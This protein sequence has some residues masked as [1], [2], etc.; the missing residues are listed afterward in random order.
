MELG[1]FCG[2]RIERRALLR[3]LTLQRCE[4]PVD[5][6]SKVAEPLLRRGG[7]RLDGSERECADG[8][9]GR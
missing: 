6:R 7:S 8:G 1:A 2:R 3:V 9:G 5:G 4:P